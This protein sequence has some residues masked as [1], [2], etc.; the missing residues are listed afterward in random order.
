MAWR[1][2][3]GLELRCL[4]SALFQ[5]KAAKLKGR[6]RPM[7]AGLRQ[8]WLESRPCARGDRGHWINQAHLPGSS[9]Y[10][11]YPNGRRA[12]RSITAH[13]SCFKHDLLIKR[14]NAQTNM[15]DRHCALDKWNLKEMCFWWCIWCIISCS[16]VRPSSFCE[17][18]GKGGK[19]QHSRVM[20]PPF[21]QARP[22]IRPAAPQVTT[23][24][25]ARAGP[26]APPAGARGR[27]RARRRGHAGR[28][29]THRRPPRAARTRA[30]CGRPH[31]R[32]AVRS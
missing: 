2:T 11:D 31:R 14:N 24:G 4:P 25:A 1:L 21:P 19:V 20:L 30:R 13:G 8:L 10:S 22:V 26:A 6:F 9:F 7:I 27:A 3:P 23:A 16:A 5:N 29:R 15:H 18:E 32:A 28:R 17:L 12:G